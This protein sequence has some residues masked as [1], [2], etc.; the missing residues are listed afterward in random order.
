MNEVKT[1][2]H[3]VPIGAR[4]LDKHRQ[5]RDPKACWDIENTID[6]AKDLDNLG[7]GMRA[8]HQENQAQYDQGG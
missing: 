4:G 3:A 1:I 8:A 5:T 2:K 6:L 7:R